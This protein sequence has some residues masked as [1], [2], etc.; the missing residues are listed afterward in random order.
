VPSES[1]LQQRKT[2][3]VSI[4]AIKALKSISIPNNFNFETERVVTL[5]IVD[6]TPYI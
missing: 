2:G 1:D 4:E 3:E 6:T 5:T